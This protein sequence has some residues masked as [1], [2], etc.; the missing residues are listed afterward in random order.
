MLRDCAESVDTSAEMLRRPLASI[1]ALLGACGA[2]PVAL[3]LAVGG[4]HIMPPMWVH[5]YGVGVSAFVA[6]AAAVVLTTVGAREQDSRTV[7]VGGGFALMASL[8]AVHGLVTPGVI[9][10][11]NGLIALTGAATLPVGGIVLT[12]AALPPFSGRN[13]IRRILTVEATIGAVI[14][15]VSVIGAAVPRLV[16]AL[17]AARSPAAIVMFG[18]GL[19]VYGALAVRAM[20]T[21]L[22]TRRFADLAVVFGIVLLATALYGA[23]FLQYYDL[24]WWIGHIFELLG[25]VVVG[26]SLVYDLRRGRRSRALVGDLRAADLVASEEAFLGARI[27]ALMVR[28]AEKDVS[29]EEHTRRVARLAVELG[30]ELGLSPARLRDLAMGGLLHDIG[31]LSLSTAILQKP[32]ALD[33][34]EYELVK[35]HPERGR[36]LLTELGGFDDSVTR[37][38]LDHHERLDGSGYPRGIGAAD[39]DLATRILAVCD[40]YDALVSDRIYR[41]AWERDEALALLR[42]ESGTAFDER[43]VVALER[44]VGDPESRSDLRVAFA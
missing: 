24:G 21:F 15:V 16:P 34:G 4:V 5:F 30:E 44:V 19:V 18:V 22:L 43:C 38:V 27:R 39:L 36:E 10:G 9:V 35:L 8:L 20:H 11:P 12:L 31:K 23:L 33:D 42:R 14:V 41:R 29:T 32:A 37:L 40:V 3:V 13:A 28:L 7:I 6:T 17:P 25:I 1:L 2:V 26:G